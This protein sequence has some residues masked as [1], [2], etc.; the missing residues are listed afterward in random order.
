M[1]VRRL[2]TAWLVRP[3]FRAAAL[4]SSDRVE[5]H[6]AGQGHVKSCRRHCYHN[7]GGGRDGSE[8]WGRKSRA[9]RRAGG[10]DQRRCGDREA[11]PVGGGYIGRR[12]PAADR[13]P[14]VARGLRGGCRAPLGGRQST[15]RSTA[16]PTSGC[17]TDMTCLPQAQVTSTG[18]RRAA[19]RRLPRD[20]TSRGQRLSPG[21]RSTCIGARLARS[22]DT[23]RRA[24]ALALSPTR[25]WTLCRQFD[26]DAGLRDSHT[27][28]ASS[29]SMPL[30]PFVVC[31]PSQGDFVELLH[32][33][34]MSYVSAYREMSMFLHHRNSDPSA[35][36]QRPGLGR[37]SCTP[38]RLVDDHCPQATPCPQSIP[39]ESLEP[40]SYS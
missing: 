31:R 14:G 29:C 6:T 25:T 20:R 32:V 35:S 13:E 27:V 26:V 7:R 9:P 1:R 12:G 37:S 4:A 22:G 17:S 16:R 40:L 10:R 8:L 21:I 39:D 38:E 24:G 3:Q 15:S 34:V 18:R 5:P 2:I 36:R 23:S 30:S 28:L 11:G 33:V 19:P